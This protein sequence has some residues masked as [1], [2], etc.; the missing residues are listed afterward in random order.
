[1]TGREVI[2]VIEETIEYLRSD[3]PLAGMT[4]AKCDSW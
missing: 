2:D 3:R 4:T 1:M